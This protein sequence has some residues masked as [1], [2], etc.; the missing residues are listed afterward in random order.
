M[1]LEAAV[2]SGER[3]VANEQCRPDALCA[4]AVC[5]IVTRAPQPSA[6]SS[7]R[8]FRLSKSTVTPFMSERQIRPANNEHNSR[9]SLFFVC[10]EKPSEELAFLS[11][12]KHVRLDN[13]LSHVPP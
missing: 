4:N 2:C 1:F 12:S 11:L 3:H 9:P 5:A 13:F 8:R 7:E 10:Y 6:V